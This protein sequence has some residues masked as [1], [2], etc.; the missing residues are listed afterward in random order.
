MKNQRLGQALRPALEASLPA[1]DAPAGRGSAETLVAKWGEVPRRGKD[2]LFE[3][4][5]SKA[6]K[7]QGG[8]LVILDGAHLLDAPPLKI[9]PAGQ[10][11][12][13][14]TL[15][16]SLHGDL[17]NPI[18]VR[19]H[20]SPLA[21]EQT[22]AYLDFQVKQAGGSENPFDATAK[23]LIHDYSSGVPRQQ[24]SHCLTA[25]GRLSEGQP[26]QRGHTPAN[27]TRIPTSLNRRPGRRPL[28]WKGPCHAQVLPA[29]TDVSLAER[30][31][32]GAGHRKAP[33]M[34]H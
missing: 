8:L 16:Q 21:K 30:D 15:R 31:F 17:L 1:P 26:H 18:T 5:L 25:F 19:F 33:S 14:Q 2:C 4:I 11:P 20:L 22:A 29:L 24:P 6:W 7:A 34:A 28:P 13:R 23:N 27:A 10:E 3:Q 32:L 9:V 12:L